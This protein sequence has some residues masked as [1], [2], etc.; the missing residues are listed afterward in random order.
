MNAPT[1]KYAI[2]A[3]SLPTTNSLFPVTVPSPTGT[4]EKQWDHAIF[5]G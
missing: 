5:V 2:K 4:W 3:G 1:I